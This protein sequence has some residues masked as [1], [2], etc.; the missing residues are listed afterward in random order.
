MIKGLCRDILASIVVEQME[1]LEVMA[2]TPK[3]T[4]LYA[5]ARFRLSVLDLKSSILLSIAEGNRS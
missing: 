5:V 1:L 3:D 4:F 2:T